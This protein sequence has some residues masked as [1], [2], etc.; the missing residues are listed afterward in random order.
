MLGQEVATLVNEVKSAGGYE[1][2]FDASLLPSGIYFYQ[3]CAGE[4]IQSKKMS[5]IK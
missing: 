5:F 2:E 3:L 4:F 1:V